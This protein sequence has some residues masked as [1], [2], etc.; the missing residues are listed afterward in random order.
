MKVSTTP[1]DSTTR[2]PP[3]ASPGGYI[4]ILGVVLSLLLSGLLLFVLTG[5]IAHPIPRVIAAALM[6]VFLILGITFAYLL[7]GYVTI[8]YELSPEQLVI[9]WAR[10]RHVVPLTAIHQIIPAVERLGANPRGWQKFWVGYYVYSLPSL[11]GLVTVVATMK[12]RRQLLVVTR[13]RQF[14]ISPER[15]VLFLEAYARFRRAVDLQR[16]GSVE[17]VQPGDLT[18][19]FADVGWTAQVPAM[20]PPTAMSGPADY[21]DAHLPTPSAPAA[22]ESH[23]SAEASQTPAN[24]LNDSRSIG[25]VVAAVLLNVLIMLTI[26]LR[27]KSLPE[28]LVL[29]WNGKGVPDRFGPTRQIWIIPTITWLVTIGN[30][31]LAWMVAAFDRFASR[32]LLAATL[33]VELMALVA[34]YMLMR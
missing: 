15:P 12:T 3:A 31:G 10:Q 19:R 20:T 30:F 33:A 28:T 6:L 29:H 16:P 24:F 13:D 4:G 34:L 8:N 11:A 14:A 1:S 17:G 5:H 2:W 23:W 9:C 18:T 27:Y 32:F 25:F 7:Y 21:R 26:L 22:T